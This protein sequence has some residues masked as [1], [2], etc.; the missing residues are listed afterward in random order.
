LGD[1]SGDGV[2]AGLPPGDGLG[3]G[4]GLGVGVGLGG[5]GLGSCFGIVSAGVTVTGGVSAGAVVLVVERRPVFRVGVA[6]LVMSAGAG[7]ASA[8]L[9]TSAPA[10]AG[11][12][13]ERRV[14]LLAMLEPVL[15]EHGWPPDTGD[16][17]NLLPRLRP[18][19]ETIV[20]AVVGIVV[21]AADGVVAM[22]PICSAT[23]V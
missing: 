7:P 20:G 16:S 2:G 8:G 10:A 3:D 9:A 15:N 22:S 4:L 1:A 21:A 14:R 6:G 23:A 5:I 19:S 17:V 18:R 13:V 12:C 11:A